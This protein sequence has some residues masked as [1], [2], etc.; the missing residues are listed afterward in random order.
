MIGFVHRELNKNICIWL[1]Q[2][3]A[4][5]TNQHVYIYILYRL[6][7]LLWEI[8]VNRMTLATSALDWMLYDPQGITPL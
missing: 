5:N 3:T 1:S 6:E 2:Y 8:R 4:I 7:A